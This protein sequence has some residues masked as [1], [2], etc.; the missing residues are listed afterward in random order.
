VCPEPD[1]APPQAPR[2]QQAPPQSLEVPEVFFA[3]RE[4]LERRDEG[5]TLIELLIVIVIIGILAAI[6]IPT[7]LNQRNRAFRAAVQSD[8]RNIAAEAE[9]YYVDKVTYVGFTTDPAYTTFRNSTGVV[10]VAVDTHFTA[11][12]YCISA[13]HLNNPT[14]IWVMRNGNRLG[15]VSAVAPI[16]AACP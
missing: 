16:V 14:E 8:L 4:R 3:Y 12:S 1:R 2:H 6:A 10:D 7:F 15:R 13:S 11:T 9:T 5:F